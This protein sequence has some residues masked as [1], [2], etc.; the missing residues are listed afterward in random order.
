MN[1]LIPPLLILAVRRVFRLPVGEKLDGNIPCTLW[2]P[3]NKSNIGGTM[4][5]SRNYICF[6]SRVSGGRGGDGGSDG[7]SDGGGGDGGNGGGSSGGG[8]CGSGG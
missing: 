5:L 1:E 3:Y 4:Y 2:A 6:A 8:D 7:G